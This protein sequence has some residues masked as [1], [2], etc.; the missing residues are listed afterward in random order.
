M[1]QNQKK[2]ILQENFDG[3][4]YEDLVTPGKNQDD[5]V[6]TINSVEKMMSVYANEITYSQMRNI[7]GIVTVAKDVSKLHKTRPRIAYIQARQTKD[8]ARIFVEFIIELMKAVKQDEQVKE[9]HELMETIVAYHR[10]FG[11]N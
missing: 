10:L 6:K 4:S 11:K 2:T 8:K 9:F 7:Y 1:E 5:V 3:L